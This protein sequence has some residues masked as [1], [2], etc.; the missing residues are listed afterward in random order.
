M[1]PQDQ[2]TTTVAGRQR[3]LVIQLGAELECALTR[4]WVEALDAIAEVEVIARAEFCEIFAALPDTAQCHSLQRSLLEP[5][6]LR[7]KLSE[8]E[9]DCALCLNNTL[10]GGWLAGVCD[11]RLQTQVG[12]PDEP[13]AID[14]VLGV[15][16]DRLGVTRPVRAEPMRLTGDTEAAATRVLRDIGFD[17][18]AAPPMLAP[19]ADSKGRLQN[20]WRSAR[21]A[22]DDDG[23]LPVIL[24]PA[25]HELELISELGGRAYFI[26]A[27]GLPLRAA[28]IRHAAVLVSDDP[29]SVELARLM[30]TPV[31]EPGGPSVSSSRS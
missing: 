2:A 21:A 27:A 4:G 7:Q 10:L 1:P 31:I 13:Q 26:A 25:G 12:T 9:F 24:L 19:R 30:G 11:R 29:A 15:L 28:V 16:F 20:D 23:L 6:R 8:R 18:G 14:A 17:A 3:I 22:F 5:L